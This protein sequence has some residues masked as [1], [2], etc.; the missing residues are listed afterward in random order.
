MN[1]ILLAVLSLSFLQGVYAQ[2]P[3]AASARYHFNNLSFKLDPLGS[4]EPREFDDDKAVGDDLSSFPQ[5]MDLAFLQTPVKNQGDRGSCTFFTS[6]ALLESLIKQKQNIEVNLSEEFLIW[7]TKGELKKYANTDGSLADANMEAVQKGGFVLERDMPFQPSW[8]TPGLPCGQFKDGDPKTPASCYSH[9]KP[10]ADITSK[11]I[12]SVGFVPEIIESK[13]AKIIEVMATKKHPVIIGVPVNPRG[14]DEKTG[15]V[16]LDDAMKKECEAQP[17]LCGG[18]SIILTGYDQVKRVFSFKNSWSPTWGKNGYGEISFDYVNKYARG[19]GV[20][21][22]LEKNINIPANHKVAPVRIVKL[23]QVKISLVSGSSG[24]KVISTSFKGAVSNMNNVAFYTSAFL[25]TSKTAEA[26][27]DANAVLVPV[28]PE[29]QKQYGPL[30]KAGTYKVFGQNG[31]SLL[32]GRLDIPELIVD[33]KGIETKDA[34]VRFST[35][36]YSDTDGWVKIT[37]KYE[38]LPFRL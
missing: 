18:H 24:A 1:R 2:D 11:V 36:V 13:T 37:R 27:T 6:N 19:T 34:F 7:K 22:R 33:T 10:G 23:S 4:L 9:N 35:Y 32:D 28:L 25:A 8:F 12:S 38:K 16:V 31:S 14:W 15:I 21:G 17:A 3:D 26:A 20:T 5:K 29:L 30:A